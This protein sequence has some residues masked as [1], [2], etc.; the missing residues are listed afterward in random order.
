MT[1]EP[2]DDDDYDEDAPPDP[3]EV[4]EGGSCCC[5]AMLGEC[6]AAEPWCTYN[7]EYREAL[8]YYE[9]QRLR[10]IARAAGQPDDRAG[11]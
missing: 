9:Q 11:G 7:P 4:G 3:W 8:A 2:Y 10:S 5:E 1:H 6:D